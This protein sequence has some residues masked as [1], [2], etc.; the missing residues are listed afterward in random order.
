MDLRQKL[1]LFLYSNY[2]TGMLLFK[3]FDCSLLG[4]IPSKF[5]LLYK[6]LLMGVSK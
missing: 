6:L 3:N 2:I 4:F 5:I 1:V